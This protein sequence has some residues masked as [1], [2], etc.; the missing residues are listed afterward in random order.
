MV[1]FRRLSANDVLRVRQWWIEHWSGETISVRGEIF[2]PDGLDGF[3]A[4]EGDTWLGLITFYIKENECEVMSLDSLQENKG[5]G[6]ALLQ[7]VIQEARRAQCQRV[8]LITTNDNLNALKFYQKRGF[9]LVTI[10]RHAMDDVRRIKP[11]VSL[12]G[13]HGIPLRDEIEL[14]L[15]LRA[16][17]PKQTPSSQ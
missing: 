8:C 9:E 14:E 15:S 5:I 10:Y 6:T 7:T 2:R 13:E 4:Y 17:R 12:I 1:A 11:G 3:I 16:N